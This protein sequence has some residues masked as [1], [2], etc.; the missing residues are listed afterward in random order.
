[1]NLI[2]KQERE[3]QSHAVVLRVRNGL[4]AI[5]KKHHARLK[6]VEVPPGPPVLSTLVAEVY[7]RDFQSYAQLRTDARHVRS[8]FEKEPG[9]VD[10]DD[11]FEA[12]RA[13]VVFRVDKEKAS[14]TGVTSEQIA[15]TLR[16]ALAGM[17]PGEGDPKDF[18]AGSGHLPRELN[19]LVIL[20]RLP[21]SDR[22]RLSHLERLGVKTPTGEIVRIAELGRFEELPAEQTIY[23]KNLR[24]VAY[25]TAETAGRTPGEAVLGLM[26][27][28]GDHPTPGGAEV[29]WT[30][31]G[32][33]KITLDVFRDL[34]LAFGGA[35]LLI[36]IL[37]VYQTGSYLIPL[38]Q[39][40]SIPLT[41]IG[42]MPGFWLLNVATGTTVGGH[43]NPVYFTATAM[44]GM[45]ALAGI[46]DRNAILLL[47]FVRH[48]R[49][50]GASLKDALI[51]SG[52]V[53]F[54]PILL[55]AGA[56]M[57]GA[58]PI[59]LDPVFSGLAWALIFGL[60]VSTAFTLFLV[61]VVYWMLYRAEDAAS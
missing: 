47:D 3:A 14:V 41:V 18:R 16:I 11:T 12:E 29:L 45:I 25:V 26:F 9:V 44:I 46:A 38:V 36:Y 55:T 56:A 52:A 39:M 34:G 35:L 58:W 7:P 42:I 33:W 15:N 19:P 1:V 40:I 5:A 30:G 2:P 21:Q 20:M 4:E 6:I 17:A 59:T 61:P 27:A 23:H 8:L 49:D 53:R 51:E 13:R 57:L 43:V 50:R 60:L 32:E 31:E 10:V 54:R 28:L 37:M 24:R 48:V 22:S